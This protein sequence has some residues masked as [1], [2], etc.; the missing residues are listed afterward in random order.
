MLSDVGQGVPAQLSAAPVQASQSS[1]APALPLVTLTATSNTAAHAVDVARAGVTAFISYI[2]SQQNV[3]NIPSSK[4][5]VLQTIK[6]P[7]TA[8]LVQGP[9]KKTA[10]LIFATML[11]A[12]I[13]LAFILENVLPKPRAVEQARPGAIDESALPAA[14]DLRR[15]A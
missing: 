3:A 2:S 13:G 5:V 1:Y 14:T 10:V 15:S 4:R 6:H 7:E 9:K 11:V 12:V 8:V